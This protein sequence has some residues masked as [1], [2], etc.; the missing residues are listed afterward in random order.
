MLH[1]KWSNDLVQGEYLL[2]FP[3]D[4]QCMAAY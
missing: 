1:I 2:L 3:N 4:I